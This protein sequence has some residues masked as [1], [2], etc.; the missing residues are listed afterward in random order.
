M[1]MKICRRNKYGYCKYGDT[2]HFKHVKEICKDNKCNIFNCEKRHPKVCSWF[3]EY[4]RCKFTTYCKFKH[5]NINNFDEIVD[6]IE[7][8]EN[9]LDEINKMLKIIEK[10]E[11]EIKQKIEAYE[12]EIEKRLNMFEIKLNKVY[13][14]LDEKD[15]IIASLQASLRK[16]L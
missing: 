10:E 7:L 12:N 3:Q 11:V 13:E 1:V 15:C 4:G 6:K 5:P 9:K 2:C 14:V 16:T 8:N